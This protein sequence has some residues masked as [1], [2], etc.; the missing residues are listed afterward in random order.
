MPRN[1]VLCCDGT[2][3]EI[4]GDSTNVLR[5][6]R[7]LVRDDRQ[8]A[9]YDA[10]VGTLADPAAI[11]RTRKLISR[12]LDSALGLTVR[13]NFC[14]AYRFL[15]RTYQP[16]DRIFLFGFSRGAYT[17]RAL[18]GAIHFLG[19]VRPE[20]E[21]LASLAWAV[22]ADDDQSL[23][24]GQRFGGGNRF[25]RAFSIDPSPD[26]HFT[27]VWD[28]VS[29]F[30]FFWNFRTLPFT[31]D[32]PSLVHVRHALAIDERRGAFGA[33]LFRPE[34]PAQHASFKQVWFAGVHSDVGGG[35][36]EKGGAL[37][38]V[39][40]VWMLRE[41][42]A[43]GLLTDADAREQHLSDPKRFPA[44]PL[45]PIHESL[46]GVW[47]LAEWLP[48]KVWNRTKRKMAWVGPNRGTRRSIADLSVL[49]KSVIDR[50]S[51]SGAEYRPPNLPA[52]YTTE[53]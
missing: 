45:G 11:T 25:K 10:G 33:N 44:D 48:R 41:A 31:A 14:E 46:Q 2:N 8:I 38:K 53:E 28:T 6:F 49:H 47:K 18:A 30:G 15:A 17:V 51:D 35:Y 43:L 13:E 20:L 23:P 12:K 50:M 52:N 3:N 16:G 29:S 34:S 9:Y 4:T 42:A 19:L 27:G 24:V 26:V 40:L 22:Y 21:G 32:N 1:I 5:L 39:S 37:S 36:L 7:T